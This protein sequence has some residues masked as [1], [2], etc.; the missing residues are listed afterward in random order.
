MATCR[1]PTMHQY[2]LTVEDAHDMVPNR[3]AELFYLLSMEKQL[4]RMKSLLVIIS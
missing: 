1:C 4:A 3:N 2:M